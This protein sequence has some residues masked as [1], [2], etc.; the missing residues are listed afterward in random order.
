M[1]NAPKSF[2]AAIVVVLLGAGTASAFTLW[3]DFR[4]SALLPDQTV[5]VRVENP[6]VAGA[7]HSILYA[8]GGVQEAPLS[9][10][11]DGPGTLEARV[12]GPVSGPRGYGFRRA[13]PGALDV[14]P[15]P[16]AAGATPAPA[17][18]TRLAADPV[19]DEPTGRAHLD[20]TECRI[21]SNGTRLYAALANVSG[22]FPVS[23]GLTFFSYLLGIKDPAVADPDTLFAM[24]HTVTAAGIIAPG[25]YQI[26]GTGVSDLVKIGEITATVL[27]AQNT[28]L[29]SCALADLEANAV[30]RRWYDTADPR[31]DVAAFS[32]RITLLG[33]TQETDRTAG[34]I[35]HLRQV[36]LDAGPNELPALSELSVPAPGSGGFV[37]VVYA[38]A[39]GHCPVIAEVTFPGG[40]AFFLRPQTLDYGSPVV[41][42]SEA[43]LPPLAQG[44]AGPASVRFSDNLSDVVTLTQATSSAALPT[45]ALRLR[46]SPNPFNPVTVI[47]YELAAPGRATLAVYG[48]DGRHVVTLAAG[49]HDRG[50]HAVS[51]NGAD[52]Q[53]RPLASGLWFARLSGDAGTVTHKLVLNK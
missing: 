4:A 51:W 53:G 28:L 38:D 29:L 32:Q 26:N 2:T 44:G 39:D 35:W 31:L 7:I 6:P 14:L 33:G 3:N 11:A 19:G 48:V 12:P 9:T 41:Y 23:S 16:L 22:G 24:I 5:T 10:V 46:A 42:R 27:A 17:D 21:G 40:E 1:P 43:A 18:L 13:L 20:L 36:R 45:P 30:F 49:Y 37:S 15:V 8:Q 25:L 34:G 50:R 52:A 47:A